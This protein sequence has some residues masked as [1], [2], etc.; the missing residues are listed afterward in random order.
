MVGCGSSGVTAGL[1]WLSSGGAVRRLA[2]VRALFSG[3]RWVWSSPRVVRPH[4]LVTGSVIAC[5]VAQGTANLVL[6]AWVSR[7]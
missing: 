6:G 4:G 7:W 3:L 5:A 1:S 2:L